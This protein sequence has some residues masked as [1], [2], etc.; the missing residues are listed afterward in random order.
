EPQ[1]AAAVTGESRAEALPEDAVTG[2]REDTVPAGTA[3][4][5]SEQPIQIARL[6]SK[7]RELEK[8][9]R[10]FFTY[11]M[12]LTATILTGA[13]ILILLNARESRRKDRIIYN[14]EQFL[15]HSMQVQE[16]ERKR[17]SLDL[18][19]SIA[20]GLRYVSL[21]AENLQDR[22]AAQKIIAVQNENIESIRRLCYNLTPPAI[23]ESNLIPSLIL[24]GQKIF[25]TGSSDFQFRVASEPAVSFEH[26]D[27]NALMNLYRIV[28]EALQ[29]IQKHAQAGEATVFFKGGPVNGSK[30]GRPASLKVIITD[31]GCGM[32]A[33]LVARLNDAT[34]EHV[35]NLHFGLR[36]IFERAKLLGGKVTY[37]SEEGCGTR[38]T[39]E[40]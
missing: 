27:E 17:I 20:Q 31:D 18:H 28:Q 35:E 36:N 12:W 16:A 22:D 38:L 15:Q 7:I 30:G 24:L 37:F 21:L 5:D 34:F 2:A 23:T 14:S 10:M 11:Y 29:N 6:E 9:H 1:V 25:D 4:F 8:S 26:W 39:V 13:F 19:D 33:G 40:I 32:D 3:A